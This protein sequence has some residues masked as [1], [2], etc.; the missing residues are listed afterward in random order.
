[1]TFQEGERIECPGTR[2]D[3]RDRPR[4]GDD[5]RMAP[6]SGPCNH[7]WGRVGPGSVLRVRVLRRGD[8]SVD[9]STVLDCPN[10]HQPIEFATV[11]AR[12]A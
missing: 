2:A 5:R 11:A 12:A 8:I 1:M 4:E 9:P 10:C 6:R 7:R 3:R